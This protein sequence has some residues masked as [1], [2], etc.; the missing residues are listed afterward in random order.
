MMKVKKIR[1]K[2]NNKKLYSSE[3]SE[4]NKNRNRFTNKY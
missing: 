1:S 2:N 3:Q 4:K